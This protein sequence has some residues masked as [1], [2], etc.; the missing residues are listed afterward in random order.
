MG[1]SSLEEVVLGDGKRILKHLF[2]GDKPVPCKSIIWPTQ[3][4][5]SKKDWEVWQ[6]WLC[7]QP[8]QP[9]TSTTAKTM[10]GRTFKLTMVA[11]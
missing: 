7:R 1:I 5:S 8:Q 9:L 10:D 11:G 3:Q 2:E 6:E 4:K